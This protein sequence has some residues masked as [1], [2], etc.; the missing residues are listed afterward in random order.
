[1]K[2]NFYDSSVRFQSGHAASGVWHTSLTALY[3]AR[4]L[5][6]LF[7]LLCLGWAAAASAQCPPKGETWTARTA[8]QANEWLSV[9]YGNGLFVAVARTGINR[10]MTSPDGITWTARTAAQANNWR[11]VTYGNGLFVAVAN[12]GTNQVMTSTDGIN[13]T[14]RTT[15]VNVWWSVVYGNDRFVAVGSDA[16]SENCV[17]TSTDG[18][19][20]TSNFPGQGGWQSVTYGNGLFVA[21][22]SNWTNRIMTS[23]DG[24]N[25]TLRTAPVEAQWRSVT[26]GNGT[27]VAVASG[28]QVMSSSDGITW[29]ERTPAEPNFWLS[30][31]HGNGTFVAVAPSGTNRVMISSDGITWAGRLAAQ[32]NSWQSVTYGN[33]LFVAVAL[34]GMNRV[35]TSLGGIIPSVSITA[36]PGN[37]IPPGTEVTFTATP[38]N[39][40]TTP[41]YQWKKNNTNVGANS[42]TYMDNTLAD[43]DI[44]TVEMTSSDPCASPTTASSSGI[45]MEVVTANPPGEALHFDG[46]D[47]L[48][49]CGQPAAFNFTDGTIELMLK[50][51][52]AGS[53]FRA[54][55][56]KPNAY[57]LYLVDN[58]LTVYDWGSGQ[59]YT[60]GTNTSV[61][62][63]TWHHVALTFGLL[64]TNNA[65][66]YI[67]GVAVTTFTKTD[68]FH[69]SAL[70]IGA[71]PGGFQFYQGSI[72][73][74]RIWNVVRTPTEI[75]ANT[76]T[77][78]CGANPGLV[79]YYQFNQGLADDNNAT[80]TTLLDG[81]GNSLN[82][83]LTGF[84]LTG[85]TSNWTA[86]GGATGAIVAPSVFIV[87]T[88]GNAVYAGYS[89]TFTAVPTNGGT[90]RTYLWKKNTV[91]VGTDPTYTDAALNPGDVITCEMTVA[92]ACASPSLATSNS[93][94]MT[95]PVVGK[96]WLATSATGNAGWQS[97]TY[98][99]GLFVAVAAFS[100]DKVMTSPDGITWTPRVAAAPNHWKSVT[101]GNGLF[102]AL[103]SDGSSRA[104]TSPDGINWTIVSGTLPFGDWEGVTFGNNRFVAVSVNRSAAPDN[105]QFMTST[106]GSNWTYAPP[107]Q[108]SRWQSVAYGNGK[109]VAVSS[110]GAYRA[111]TSTDGINWTLSTT[112]P[113]GSW[114]CVTYGNGVF[115]AVEENNN[116]VMTSTDDGITWTLHTVPEAN[117]WES[118]TFG[119]GL[120]VAVAETGTNRVMTSP[121]GITWTPYPAALQKR[122]FGVTYGNDRFVAVSRF[123]DKAM[124]S[125]PSA[126]AVRIAG[127]APNNNIIAGTSV[128]F[129]ATPTDGGTT[130][131]YQWKKNNNNVGTDSPT[132]TDNALADGDI[133]TVVMTSSDPCASSAT[134]TSNPIEMEVAPIF[135]TGLGSGYCNDQNTPVILIGSE[136]PNGTFSGPGITDEGNG[137]ALFIPS[138][139]GTGG[140][141]TYTIGGSLIRPAQLTSTTGSKSADLGGGTS[142]SQNVAVYLCGAPPTFTGLNA[143][144]CDLDESVTLTGSAP[145]GFFTGSGVTDNGDGT[146]T[147]DPGAARL[148]ENTVRYLYSGANFNGAWAGISAGLFHSVAIKT[149]GTLWAWG[150]NGDGQFGNGTDTDS[151]IPVQIDAAN[152]WASVS[153]GGFHTL[154][155]KTDGT[156]WAWGYNDLG[157][158]GNGTNTSS[159]VP[160]QIGTDTDWASISAGV[161]FSIAMKSD[162]T[163]WTW[164][165]NSDGQLGIG[166]N[167]NTNAPMQVGTDAN[168]ASVSAGDFHSLA[169]K[170]DGTLWAW[171]YNFSGQLGNNSNIKS[172]LPIQV[173]TD[174]DWN[175][176]AAGREHSLA[177]KTNGT[178]WAWGRNHKGQL[179]NGANITSRIPIQAGTD[180]DWISTD[181]NDSY[182]IGIKTD[183]TLWAW[184]FNEEGQLG[185]GSFADSNT[186]VKIGTDA[187]WISAYAGSSHTMGLKTDG[188]LQTW[189]SNEYG[190][191]GNG[192]SGNANIPTN[193]VTANSEAFTVTITQCPDFTGLDAEYCGG[194]ETVLLT[195]NYAPE[196][197]FSGP[198]ITDNGDGTASFDPTAAG[199]G[200]TITYTYGT[201]WKSASAGGY[202]AMAVQAN[203]S[204]WGWGYNYYG[205]LGD[206][207]TDDQYVPVASG[208]G[209]NDWVK[210]SGG[211]Y[212]SLGLKTDGTLWAWGYGGYGE[213]GNGADD[214]S[215][216]PVQVG[217]DTDWAFIKAGNYVSYGIKTNGT[218]WAWGNGDYDLFG[219]G[220]TDNR[221][222]PVQIGTDTDWASVSNNSQGGEH[223][224]A[225]KTD[226]SLW[227]WGYNNDDGQFGDGTTDASPT[228]VQIGTDTDWASADA[229]IY[230]SLGLKTDGTLWAWG[231]GET[232]ELGN[233][234]TDNSLAP[235]QVGTETN[236]ASAATGQDCS[237]ATKTDG[238]LWSWGYN[239]NG[240]LGNGTNDDSLVPIQSGIAT[241]WASVWASYQGFVLGL[242][243]DG[244]LWAWGYQEYGEL[245]DGQEDVSSNVPL[246]VGAPA[247]AFSKNVTVL[248][249][250]TEIAISNISASDCK[251]TTCTEDDTYTADVTVIY[252]IKP[253]SGT[254]ALTGPTIVG[255]V[256][257]VNVEDLDATAHTFT[258]VTMTA[259]GGD[260]ALTATF[261]EGC[262][263]T[264]ESAEVAPECGINDCDITDIALSNVGACNDNGTTDADDD[265]FTADVTVTFAYA[266]EFETLV[267]TDAEGTILATK[268]VSDG[269]L[270]TTTWTFEDV[271]LP[272]NGQDVVLTAE[273][274]ATNRPAGRTP[275]EG[276]I[277]TSGVLMTAP[278]SCSCVPTTAFTACPTT[279]SVNTASGACTAAVTYSAVAN[280]VPEPSYAYEFTGVTTNSGTGI[281]SGATFNKGLT[282]VKITATNDC[283]SATCQFTVTVVDNQPPTI[284]CPNPTT[285]SCF[286]NVPAPNTASV[287]ASDNCGTPSKEHLLSLPYDVECA[288]RFKVL[289]TYRATDA[290]GNS[291]TCSQVIAVFDNV[292][293]VFTFVP[294][295]VTVQ[296]NSVP[297][298]GSPTASDNCGGSVN[299]TY[300]GQTRVNGACTDS[301]TLTRQW[302][303]TDACGNT[304]TATQRI[305][306]IDS[307]KPA[308]VSTPAN[309][310]VQCDAIP[311]PA[312]PTATDNCDNTVSITYNGQT[313]TNGTC[314]NA[315]AL[316]RRWTA[317]DNCGNTVSVSQRITVVDNGKPVFTA[318]P[319]NTTIACSQALP[320]VATPTAS[321]ACGGAV[322]IAY[323]G[324]SSTSGTC[325]GNYQIKRTWRAT[326]VCGNSTAATQ[327]IQV[328]DNGAPVFV[329]VPGPVTIECNQPLPPLVNPTA[330]DACGGYVHITFLG[331]VP[332]GSG[333]AADYTITRT[334]RA[335]DLCGNTA[336]ATQVITVQGNNFGPQGAETREDGAQ[337]KTQ[338]SK[339][340]TVYP[341]P[342]TDRVWIDLT[343]FAGEAVTVSILSDLGQLV[344]ENRIPAVE[345]L[346]LLISLREAGAAAGIY[347]VSLRSG[348]GVVAT[349][350]VLIK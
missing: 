294:A 281:G 210:V 298:V 246:Q 265:Y 45:T 223:T 122:W 160:V 83:T 132:Y 129:T 12:G 214:D 190:Q 8:A 63:G 194:D 182:S 181:A 32:A 230:H 330:T 31:T 211:Y 85:T 75:S 173:G 268:E 336:T 1:M 291:K 64:G 114:N 66:I 107:P 18:I 195:G 328:S 168:W 272:A 84:A 261:S 124:V 238:T 27:F 100:S 174:T 46:A 204:L 266:P 319:A 151:D 344:W 43:G 200:G 198:G 68:A 343:D 225:V 62:D 89:V 101:F 275:D 262:A 38:T 269:L 177:L 288:N 11:S 228:P 278:A 338:N 113:S 226:G 115:V 161:Y 162:G 37:S 231:Y 241:N 259:D 323:L 315:Y 183:G 138:E 29:T 35:M 349:R 74:V 215:E 345:D 53:G 86:P 105:Y 295:N 95:C 134:A 156:L 55:V 176:A 146:A 286:G 342:T 6:P 65:T 28:G 82:G 320:P 186:P 41:A 290:S 60:A 222:T 251:N 21:V 267:L 339:L 165:Q 80:E 26:H 218:L 96:D 120:F 236:W 152:D 327:T 287:T 302:T 216:V 13:W 285:V 309:I 196:G 331:N 131:T 184:G 73:E 111:M 192:V 118:V 255:T 98:G 148:G 59:S 88:P 123:S 276:C 9:T 135:F 42:A 219:D 137:T 167:T 232:G 201:I 303:A 106:D 346:Q 58:V 324:Q 51:T 316:T 325:P 242:Q 248:P 304:K 350:V 117:D 306:V 48:V 36:D 108:M 126:P 280:G 112:V 293:P 3:P 254:L 39:G 139:A 209:S 249:S 166:I 164:G 322:T 154:A 145:L 78:L 92:D 54:L 93:I 305:N 70:G 163:I 202:H 340:K 284:S 314:P 19:N 274:Y 273:F 233:G 205:A 10:V 40:G 133:I 23:T 256:P 110:N 69:N 47:D 207:S 94:T 128:T 271:Q 240:Q 277:F 220:T 227:A 245:G 318:F 172:N 79:A 81:S 311:A 221:N 217:A 229:G 308:F 297:A 260:I 188:S 307:Q 91:N 50:T 180:A 296:C 116:R 67:D 300:N 313:R 102:V 24:I 289:R 234:T 170:T 90:S 282:N 187:N 169:T 130:P 203:G 99:N 17:M 2:G 127:D 224:L 149:D 109:F 61:V 20:W 150:Y 142:T 22:A 299:I 4:L 159:N 264:E 329:T 171:G 15:P 49:N 179:G 235:I 144:Y 258:G 253:A 52:N 121:D 157:A 310:T 30:V 263:K 97:V 77:E 158:L 155:L 140:N 189:G 33:G 57:G 243:T 292:H 206:G 191:S 104:M 334:W 87:A 193:V 178:L 247:V 208:N 301:Y 213:L 141:I 199:T 34:T 312:S 119:G 283:G 321:D 185:N 333:C 143:E 212:H 5:R 76:A 270:C 147:F 237:L 252:S 44:I 257:A 348:R 71:D 56:T 244:S 337:L 7:F 25:W 16:F 125:K 332:S 347:T 317:A 14:G 197:T 335:D 239:V 103:S 341:N 136:A 250:P 279:Q 153:A 175:K 72:D 326:D